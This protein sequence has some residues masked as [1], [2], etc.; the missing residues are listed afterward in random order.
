KEHRANLTNQL[1]LIWLASFA[2][3]LHQQQRNEI[4]KQ[5]SSFVN[6]FFSLTVSF[7]HPTKRA[8]QNPLTHRKLVT[9]SPVPAA[10]TR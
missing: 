6:R 5:S 9:H 3:S 10:C 7:N 2:A 8:L 1:Y 4:M